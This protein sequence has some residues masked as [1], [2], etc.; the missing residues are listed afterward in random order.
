MTD[1]G[2]NSDMQVLLAAML[3]PLD[4]FMHARH[5]QDMPYLDAAIDASAIVGEVLCRIFAC[6]DDDHARDVVVGKF[7]AHL[8]ISVARA[9]SVVLQGAPP[10]GL[11]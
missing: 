1:P 5:D 6:I 10:S 4:G 8:P 3:R 7:A 11:Q 2:Y 9:R